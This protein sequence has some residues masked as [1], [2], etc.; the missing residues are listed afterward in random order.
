MRNDNT[1]I[2]YLFKQRKHQAGVY[3]ADKKIDMT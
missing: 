3:L 1:P 2:S